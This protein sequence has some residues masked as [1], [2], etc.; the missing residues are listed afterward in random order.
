[1]SRVGGVRGGLS[2]GLIERLKGGRERTFGV[3]RRIEGLLAGPKDLQLLCS[4]RSPLR[5]RRRSAFLA[6]EVF[7]CVD[8]PMDLPGASSR[9]RQV[10]LLDS[11]DL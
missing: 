3:D 11:R 6:A 10:G 4:S 8:V 9:T 7:F 1:M 2:P 5:L